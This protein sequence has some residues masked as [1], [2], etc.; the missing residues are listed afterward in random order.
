MGRPRRSRPQANLYPT[1]T[2]YI[3]RILQLLAAGTVAGVMFFF[4]SHRNEFQ[5]R[6]PW[7]FYFVSRLLASLTLYGQ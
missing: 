4:L 1:M 2:Y 7:V 3:A 5:Y 6:L